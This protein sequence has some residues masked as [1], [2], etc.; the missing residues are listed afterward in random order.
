MAQ[1][2]SVNVLQMPDQTDF[3]GQTNPCPAHAISP[4]KIQDVR[5]A[6]TAEIAAYP[7]SASAIQVAYYNNSQVYTGNYLVGQTVAQVITAAN[8]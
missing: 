8:A 5:A 3:A 7:G 4:T 1:L 6:T 2:F